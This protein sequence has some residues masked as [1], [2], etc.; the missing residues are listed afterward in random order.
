MFPQVRA[1]SKVFIDGFKPEEAKKI[2][3]F[4][5]GYDYGARNPSAFVVWGFDAEN[6]AYALWELYEP[7]TNVA[8]HVEKIKR[9]PYYDRIEYIACDPS[10]MSKTQQS[11]SGLK[12]LAE[13][14]EDHGLY[15]TKGRRGQDVTIA[16]V[17]NA[18]HWSDANNPTAFITKACPA[19]MKEVLDL[20]WDKHVSE[21]LN[22]RKN[23]PE[24]IRD[25]NN[26]WWDATAVLFDSQ[27]QPFIPEVIKP[28]AGT[29]KQAVNDLR[30]EQMK[31]RARSSGIHVP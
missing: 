16:Q 31:Q 3:R 11:A 27:P 1:G 6:M 21:A 14:F 5:A 28:T 30:L 25:K 12:T 15:L 13:V 19:G 10:I 23:A 17:F 2:M 20:R 26:H 24:R 8:E 18:T 9:C 22:V 4:Y 7:C 29:F